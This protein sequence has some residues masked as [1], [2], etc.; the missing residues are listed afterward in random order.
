VPK[1][2]LTFVLPRVSPVVTNIAVTSAIAY[3]GML[4]TWQCNTAGLLSVSFNG[5]ILMHKLSD[6]LDFQI[7]YRM[8][9]NEFYEERERPIKNLRFKIED[10][11]TQI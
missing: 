9:S 8:Y 1:H 4:S 2:F 10:F 7:F 3:F 6:T 11:F 5:Q